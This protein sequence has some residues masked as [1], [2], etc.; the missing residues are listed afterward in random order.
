MKKIILSTAASILFM[1]GCCSVVEIN[2]QNPL[3]LDRHPEIVE[4]DADSVRTVLG[5]NEGES[6]VVKGKLGK[7]LPYQLTYDGKL[8]FPVDLNAGETLTYK[9]RKG[10]PSDFLHKFVV[11]TIQIE[12]MTSAG[13]MTW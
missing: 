3:D 1:T 4:L 5:L 10:T 2:V 13:R 11:I 8:I 7:D 6:F 12:L 9:I